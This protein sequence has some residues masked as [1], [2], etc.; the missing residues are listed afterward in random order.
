MEN[1]AAAE[2]MPK[3][4]GVTG[5]TIKLIAIIVMFIDHTGA[6]ILERMMIKEGMGS[7]MDVSSAAMFM[8]QNMALYI[9]DIVLRLVGRLGFPIF[10]FLLIEGFEHTHNVKKYASRLFLFALISE[11]PFDLGFKGAFFYWGY[12]NVFFTL[13]FGLLVMIGLRFI[14]EKTEWNKIIKAIANVLVLVAGM[15]A[16]IAMQTDY[17]AFGVLTVAVMYFFRNKKTLSAGLGCTTLTV[18]SPTEITAFLVLIP[19]HKYNGE[20][21]WNIK[22][23]F[24]AFYPVHI[25]ILYLIACALGLSQVAM[26]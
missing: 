24:Y 3:K 11:I 7:I 22:W 9:S 8:Q 15:G 21:G 17:S 25:L 23:L 20:R 13:L 16:A 26:F 1:A 6:I 2:I 10:C 18:M 12:Q 14:E 4:K 19:I 5:S